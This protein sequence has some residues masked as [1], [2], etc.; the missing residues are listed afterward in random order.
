[1][2]EGGRPTLF[3]IPPHRAFADALAAGLIARLRRRQDRPRA[4]HRPRPQQPRRARD[5]RRVRAPLGRRAAAAAADPGRRSRARRPDRRRVRAAGGRSDPARDRAGRTADA[6]RRSGPAPHA[7]RRRRRRGAAARG[8]SRA[9]ARSI[10]DRA[11]R[12]GAPRATSPPISPICRSTGRSRS[13]GCRS[14]CATGRS[15]SP[16]AAGS[17]LPTAATACSMRSPSAGRTAR[18]RASSSRRASPPPRPPSRGCSAWSRGS[19]GAWSC[20]PASTS[21]CP[22]PN[23]TR[24]ARTSPIR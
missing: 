17:I 16:S 3:T 10:A 9:H 8:R 14:S 24:S 11:G 12:S 4:G 19:S 22:P 2:A 5:H 18:R 13:T 21:T 23:G 20:C 7:G 15:C 6:A 1:M